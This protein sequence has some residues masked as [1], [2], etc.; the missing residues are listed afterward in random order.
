MTSDCRDNDRCCLCGRRDSLTY[1]DWCHHTFCEH[2]RKRP[3]YRTKAALAWHLF[4]N[5]PKHCSR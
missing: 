2:C 4:G 5:P 1:C 3:F